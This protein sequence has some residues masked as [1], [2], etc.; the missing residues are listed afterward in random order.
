MNNFIQQKNL[1]YFILIMILSLII[2]LNSERILSIFFTDDISKNYFLLGFLSFLLPL[3]S[4]QYFPQYGLRTLSK[5]F[6]IFLSYLLS[7]I[8]AIMFS[9]Y[10]IK[11]F[12]MYGFIF[13]M[14]FS[15]IIII[16]VTYVGYIYFF[17]KLHNE[18]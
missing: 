7:S 16:L 3:T 10:M 5:T 14:Y 9:P 4:L 17:K 8:F 15:Q 12:E 18:N 2:F 6:P 13:G 1:K 11:G